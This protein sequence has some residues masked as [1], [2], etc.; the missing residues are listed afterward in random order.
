MTSYVSPPAEP[1]PQVLA[2]R[3]AAPAPRQGIDADRWPDV[4]GLP[5]G[6][7]ARRAVAAVLVRS[8]LRRLPLRVRWGGGSVTGDAGPLLDVRDPEAFFRRIGADGLIGFGESYL[9]REWDS[10]DLVGVLEVLAAHVTRLVPPALQRLRGVWAH[11]HPGAERNTPDG[12]RGNIRRHYDLSNDLFA[13]FLDETMTYSSALFTDPA[14]DG[15]DELADAQRR[16]ADR[17][18]DL[19]EVR[20]GTRLLEIGTG[21]GDLALRAARRGARVRT[22]TLSHEQ[23]DLALRR[24]ARAGL[25][26]RVS[27]ELRD[28]REVEGAY[29]AVVSVE[30][31]EAVGEEYWPVYFDALDR[32]TVPGG[33]VALQT[34]TMPHDRMLATRDTYT[35]I[36]KYVFPGGMLPSLEAIRQATAHTGLRVTSDDG[37]GTHYA[38][39]L[40]LWRERFTRR[41]EAV[42]RLG[43]DATFR[44]MWEFY[45]AYSEAGFRAGY[46]DVRQI[47]FTADGVARGGA[48]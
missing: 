40:R 32:L 34:I 45:L 41:A 10:D 16:K 18:L 25:A 29:D 7:R 30:M 37:F 12:A 28:Y 24:I 14:A 38:R 23:R 3:P 5:P 9:A 43:F 13:L 44:R 48:R 6:S 42:E 33:R 26:D 36:H 47:A 31:V 11:R 1:R 19:A 35:W 21:W 39:T 20:T 2:A 27:V 46:L 22:V 17:L 8:A 4:A 15:W